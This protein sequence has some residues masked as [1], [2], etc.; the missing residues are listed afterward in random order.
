MNNEEMYKELIEKRLQRKREQLQEI[1]VI[2]QQGEVT[3]IEKK[4]YVETKAVIRELENVLDMAETM[5]I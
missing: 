3:A 5:L 2:M 1:E 4:N